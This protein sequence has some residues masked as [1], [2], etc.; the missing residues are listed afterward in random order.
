MRPRRTGSC[1]GRPAHAA[2]R[3]REVDV[4]DLVELLVAHAHEQLV[5]G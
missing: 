3:P 5:A 4:E 2:E 1:L